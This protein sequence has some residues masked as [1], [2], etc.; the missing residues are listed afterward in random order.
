M[1]NK[2]M[3]NK[4]P[5]RVTEFLGAGMYGEKLQKNL[6]ECWLNDY[7]T[8]PYF[9]TPEYF[10]SVNME[11]LPI[12]NRAYG[13]LWNT[14]SYVLFGPEYNYYELDSLNFGLAGCVMKFLGRE[15]EKMNIEAIEQLCGMKF[16]S[17]M[18]LPFM[19]INPEIITWARKNMLPDPNAVL[20]DKTYR[21]IYS[22]MFRD[23]FRRKALGYAFLNSYYD[24]A[25]KAGNYQY[26]MYD[27]GFHGPEFLS[28][29]FQADYMERPD[30]DLWTLKLEAGF[31]LRRRMDDTY[32]E[33]WNFLTAVMKQ[34][35]EFWFDRIWEG[36]ET[37]YDD[38]DPGYPAEY[39]NEGH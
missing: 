20:L 24:V 38:P 35:D 36:W 30:I 28:S 29:E 11:F 12:G 5:E 7:V 39:S 8:N 32:D 9:H 27:Q 6:F 33:C 18:D 3:D 10:E 19:H 25:E 13:S 1:K 26:R 22:V 34:Y 2:G 15:P 23:A 21:S 17:D 37:M 31:W 14:P 4:I 16:Y